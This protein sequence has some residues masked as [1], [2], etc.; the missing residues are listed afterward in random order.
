MTQLA[1]LREHYDAIG[2]RLTQ[3]EASINL[4]I[5]RL[6]PRIAELE[7]EGYQFDHR[8]VKVASRHGSARVADYVLTALPACAPAPMKQEQASI[9]AEGA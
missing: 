7:S 8:M 6:A 4:G 2:V 3:R 5:G 9:F 1:A